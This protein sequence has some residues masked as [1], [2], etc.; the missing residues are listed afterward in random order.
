M[1][2]DLQRDEKENLCSL[3]GFILAITNLGGERLQH[4]IYSQFNAYPEVYN[5]IECYI[6]GA[7]GY[8]SKVLGL[9]YKLKDYNLLSLAF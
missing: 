8:L 1:Q 5:I 2:F 4:L 7:P 3:E 6:A 9:C